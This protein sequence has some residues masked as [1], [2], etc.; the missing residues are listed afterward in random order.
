M[1]TRRSFASLILALLV[2]FGISAA[3]AFAWSEVRYANYEQLGWQVKKYS[4]SSR[5]VGGR[6]HLSASNW[7]V[8]V[9]T[10]HTVLKHPVW[11]IQGTGATAGTHPEVTTAMSQCY[12]TYGTKVSGTV[13]TSC[14]KRVP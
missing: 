13:A 6:I 10:V 2:V 14:W 8:V 3:P 7:T 9:Q 4:S 12:W 11:T 5:I 1:K